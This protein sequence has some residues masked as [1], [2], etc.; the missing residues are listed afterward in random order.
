MTTRS[1][2][3]L[4]EGGHYFEGPRWREGRWWVSDFYDHEVIALTPD[5]A[6]E[7]VLT[8]PGQPSG[9]GWLPDSSLLVVSMLDH[10]LLRRDPDGT[11]TEHADLSEHCGGHL[12]DLVV[13]TAG[14]AFVGDFGFDLFTGADPR[15]TSLKRVDLDGSVHVAAEDLWFPNGSVVSPDGATLL[16]GETFGGRYTAFTIQPD[17]SLTDRRIWGQMSP[18]PAPG[19]LLE[20]LSGGGFAPDGCSLDAEGHL[21]SADALGGRVARL[22]PGGSIVDEVAAPA[23]LSVFACA[24]G[25]SDGRTLL[26]CAAPDFSSVGRSST[27]EAVLLTT[28][29]EVPHAGLP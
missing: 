6:R 2:R 13:D 20:M 3:T 15:A 29:V 26:L 1:L 11:V 28:T 18:A 10:R 17:G 22:A 19:P 23:G 14:R 25:G 8:V 7:V 27:R 24:L 4:L 12:N 21:W 16:V 5:G 9:L